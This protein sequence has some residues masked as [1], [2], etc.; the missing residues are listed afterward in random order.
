MGI[1]LTLPFSSNVVIPS[2]IS[3][4]GTL[5]SWA[6]LIEAKIS[7]VDLPSL[8]DERQGHLQAGLENLVV[9]KLLTRLCVFARKGS[10]CI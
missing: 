9:L 8:S 5:C 2:R 10:H 3:F 4:I 7:E 1:G 6:I